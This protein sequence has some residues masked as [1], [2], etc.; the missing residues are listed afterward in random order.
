MS[1]TDDKTDGIKHPIAHKI[2]V[3]IGSV[4]VLAFIFL[5]VIGIIVIHGFIVKLMWGWFVVPLGLPV[6]SIVH[7]IGL[8]LLFKYLTWQ[9]RSKDDKDDSVA[10]KL[11]TALLYPFLILGLG[12]LTHLFM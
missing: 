1:E 11:T 3:T 2:G 8:G 5:I 9:H 10:I 4:L 7:A 12:Y 6:L